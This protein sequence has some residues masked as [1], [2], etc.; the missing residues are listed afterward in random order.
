M[1]HSKKILVLGGGGFIGRALVNKLSTDQS[2]VIHVADNFSRHNNKHQVFDE[3]ETTGCERSVFDVD[4]CDP[5]SF[6]QFDS[7]YDEVYLLAAIVGVGISN[8]NPSK[9]L[10]INS[11]IVVNFGEWLRRCELKR[12]VF[13]SSSE[14][15]AGAVDQ[16][17]ASVPTDETVLL[18][19]QDISHPRFSY[20]ASKIFGEAAIY[21][22]AKDFG[23]EPLVVRYHNV[24][25]P[26]M[27]YE[28]VIPHLVNRFSEFPDRF[29]IYGPEQTRAFCY[30]TDAVD[31][32]SLVMERGV[33]GEIYH[34]GSPVETSI[35]V[36]TQM[37]GDIF[38]FNGAYDV[39]EP[40]PG[41]VSRRC[42]DIS[43]LKGLGFDPRVTLDSGL[44]RTV[45][46]YRHQ[47]IRT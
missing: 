34:I 46:W 15:Y 14:V 38:G 18:S 41:S 8:E 19:I 16:G 5:V 1:A 39:G 32:T 33:Q 36:L 37:V 45:A 30:V 47:A 35:R 20:A 9:V 43:K 27:G 7:S 21:A 17:V 24:Y 2:A 29:T 23:F 26:E 22:Y 4:L 10:E 12:V 3:M 6:H 40:Y 28:H 25:G 31:A 42:P 11:K 13:S 44:H